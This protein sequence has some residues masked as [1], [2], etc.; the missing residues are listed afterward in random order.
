MSKIW[1][2]R[3]T[4]TGH[5]VKDTDL[6]G[7]GSRI[8]GTNKPVELYFHSIDHAKMRLLKLQ[9]ALMKDNFERDDWFYIKPDP[10]R[11]E[12][13]EGKVKPLEK[14]Y[15]DCFYRIK[16]VKSGLY[17]WK[18]KKFHEVGRIYKSLQGV[19]PVITLLTGTPKCN[20][21][22]TAKKMLFGKPASFN[23]EVEPCILEFK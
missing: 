1:T 19:E 6:H 11:F 9:K 18:A 21:D 4:L 2:I 23:I 7:G 16:D 13:L 17:Y 12:V 22:T 15:P 20:R 5:F 10:A 14:L 3:D 8:I